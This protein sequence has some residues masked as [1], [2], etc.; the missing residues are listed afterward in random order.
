MSAP[1]W[2]V[3]IEGDQPEMYVNAAAVARMA[4]HSPLGITQAM[5][6]LKAALPTDVFAVVES[7]LAV[8][9]NA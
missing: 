2:H 6:N 3:V 8:I 9:A 7:E 1:D 5:A 4:C